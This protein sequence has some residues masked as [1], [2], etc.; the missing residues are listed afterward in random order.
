MPPIPPF[1]I[2]DVLGVSLGSSIARRRPP[3]TRASENAFA[4]SGSAPPGRGD[5]SRRR[6]RSF[7][8]LVV[9][10]LGLERQ[11]VEVMRLGEVGSE[12]ERL[13]Q[14]VLSA[15]RVSFLN[16]HAG[17][18]DESVGA[19]A[20][21]LRDPGERFLR[22]A[23]VS[24]QKKTDAVVV[25]TKGSTG[26]FPPSSRNPFQKSTRRGEEDGVPV[27]FYTESG[28]KY[29]GGH[30]IYLGEAGLQFMGEVSEY[31]CFFYRPQRSPSLSIGESRWAAAADKAMWRS[32]ILSLSPR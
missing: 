25:E 18:I 20:V 24:L 29:Q 13:F 6:A 12:S 23:E 5:S 2:L 31:L 7:D 27:T 4:R 1:T 14:H 32:K 22:P 19:G 3:R 26:P 17:D 11:T 28:N 8:R 10:P 15:V 16:P 9:A 30:A 21:R